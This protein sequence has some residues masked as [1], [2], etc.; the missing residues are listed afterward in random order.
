MI[1]LGVSH[2]TIIGWESKCDLVA[3][4]K[5]GSPLLLLNSANGKTE[6][7]YAKELY[8]RLLAA[9][10]AL[11][12]PLRDREQD[13]QGRWWILAA[14]AM[15]RLKCGRN[16]LQRWESHC[17]Y[18]KKALERR[19]RV[20]VLSGGRRAG[21]ET[22]Y[23][24]SEIDAIRAA[25]KVK[26]NGFYGE[27]AK[28]RLIARAAHKELGLA[29]ATIRRAVEARLLTPETIGRKNTAKLTCETFDREELT[30]YKKQRDALLVNHSIRG[31]RFQGR[32]MKHFD[33]V[34]P[35]GRLSLRTAAKRAK[36]SLYTVRQWVARG[37][38]NAILEK[39]PIGTGRPERTVE[40]EDIRREKERIAAKQRE[41]VPS[42]PW[43]RS[44]DLPDALHI[45]HIG[46]RICLGRLLPHWRES[47]D[48]EYRQARGAY[49]Y[50]PQAVRDLLAGLSPSQARAKLQ[51]VLQGGAP[52]A[53]GHDATSVPRGRPDRN[54]ILLAYANAARTKEPSIQDKEI[55]KRFRK[56]NPNHPIFENDNPEH[57]FRTAE[58]RARHK[59]A[60]MDRC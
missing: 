52:V 29:P 58:Y 8:D 20:R 44:C 24:E 10:E 47:G 48:I 13:E 60:T 28:L 14:R 50:T 12:Q 59:R 18:I 1:E 49:Y 21:T 27:E 54:S 32:R 30:K 38:V 37:R 51:A 26:G 39:P 34:F 41:S 45:S 53:H 2:T 31:D 55:L 11:K 7:T 16:T 22:M 33:G 56:E 40:L 25:L 17:V 43:R 42:A 6:A 36:V 4:G 57:A 5:L 35:S 15:K 19:D 46:E 3:E 23:M 9:S